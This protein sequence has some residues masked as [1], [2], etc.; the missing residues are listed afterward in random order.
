MQDQQEFL[1]RTFQNVV[2]ALGRANQRPPE[3]EILLRHHYLPDSAFIVPN[4][5]FPAVENCLSGLQKLLLRTD[6]SV[7]SSAYVQ[8][9]MQNS[10]I[11]NAAKMCAGGNL[12]RFL[13]C[14]PNLTHL[15]LNFPKHQHDHNESFL[16]WLS[17]TSPPTGGQPTDAFFE[18]PPINLA[19]LTALDLGQFQVRPPIIL[20][21]VARFAP[22]LKNLELWKMDLNDGQAIGTKLNRWS[23]FFASLRR[24]PQ[25]E[26]THIKV[27]MLSQDRLFVQFKISNEDNVP[28][29]KVKEYTGTKM[30]KIL[31][32]LSDQVTV[33]W[34]QEEEDLN[35]DSDEEEDEDMADD[36]DEE[37]DDDDGNHA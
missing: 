12:R 17:Q 6:P 2:Y 9:G 37:Y 22:T 14:T 25:L 35:T 13:A 7:T 4:F 20:N 15:R 32:E 18:P 36:D 28:M 21:L 19:H 16:Q 27:G 29:L 26:L 30:D 34:P 5:V 8:S 31:E 23:K 3:L 33:L 1:S 24:V 11:T 10:L